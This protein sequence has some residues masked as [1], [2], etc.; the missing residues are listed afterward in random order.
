V[1]SITQAFVEHSIESAGVDWIT[2]TAQHG[3][4]RWNMTEFARH[5]RERLMDSEKPIKQS[6]RLGYDGWQSESFFYGQ[7]EGGTIIIASG[8][9]AHNVFRSARQVSDH[10]SRLDLQVTVK[11]PVD[12]PH[13]AVQAFSTIKSGSPAR[14]RVRNVTLISNH[15][16]GETVN[17]GKRK[18]DTYGRIYDKASESG[19]APPRSLWRYEVEFKRS[20]ANAIA[21]ALC[22]RD[23]PET[24]AQSV[25]WSWFDTRGVVPIFNRRPL[26]RP[27]TPFDSG[28]SHNVLEWFRDSLSITVSKAVKRYGLP[29][30]LEALCLSSVVDSYYKGGA[31][32]G[33][34]N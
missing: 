19:S 12:R 7:R 28:E 9:T 13:L 5:E 30:V 18:S 27:R 25:V 34:R 14:V 4:S 33:S 16:R 6:Y 8:A 22:A 15:P 23:D 29:R 2:A 32:D 21:D 24:V 3:S 10:I 11:T 17:V 31:G 20:P 26:V 1:Q